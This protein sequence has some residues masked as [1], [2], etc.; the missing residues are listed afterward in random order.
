R[1]GLERLEQ[2]AARRALHAVPEHKDAAALERPL[3]GVPGLAQRAV[4][5]E[6]DQR[7]AAA[8]GAHLDQRARQRSA[9]VGPVWLRHVRRQVEQRRLAVI[10]RRA[11]LQLT[12]LVEPEP[13]PH[14]REAAVRRQRRRRQHRRSLLVEQVGLQQRTHVQR[15]RVQ[16][17]LTAGRREPT[18]ALGVG[19]LDDRAAFGA[20][21]LLE[22]QRAGERAEKRLVLE[23]LLALERGDQRVEL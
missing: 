22:T 9:V 5:R 1:V 3:D 18:D 2:V 20:E 7:A 19:A 11:H 10:E 13:L 14:E 8:S 21:L 4:R 17:D 12:R 23:H 16:A 6:Q 15:R